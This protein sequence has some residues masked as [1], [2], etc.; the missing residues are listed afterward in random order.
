MDITA[1]DIVGVVIVGLSVLFVLYLF[2]NGNLRNGQIT[3]TY[4]Q[5]RHCNYRQQI[6]DI[7]ADKFTDCSNLSCNSPK[8]VCPN[9]KK[10][11]FCGL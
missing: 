3:Y 7:A 9:C 1:F 8:S 2:L 11:H 5:C 10:C 6:G 4:K